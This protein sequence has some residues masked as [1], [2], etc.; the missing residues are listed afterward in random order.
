[1]TKHDDKEWVRTNETPLP[2]AEVHFPDTQSFYLK[3][4]D[5]RNKMSPV[6]NLIAMLEDSRLDTPEGRVLIK[7]EIENVKRIVEYLS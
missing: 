7:A 1:M 6:K 4:S 2:K 5:V 3:R